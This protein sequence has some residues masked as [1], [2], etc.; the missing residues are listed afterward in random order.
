MI[1]PFYFQVFT[2]KV[3]TY[4]HKDLYMK[5]HNNFIYNNHYMKAI[6]IPINTEHHI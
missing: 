1:Q 2:P 6:Q 5:A 4:P 3:K